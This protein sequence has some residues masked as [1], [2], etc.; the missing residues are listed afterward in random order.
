MVWD[1][2][3]PGVSASPHANLACSEMRTEE[4][5]FTSLYPRDYI[6]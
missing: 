1:H 5:E 2:F 6:Q 3:G 4:W